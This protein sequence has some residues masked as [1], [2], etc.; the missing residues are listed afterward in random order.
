MKPPLNKNREFKYPLKRAQRRREPLRTTRELADEA[1]ISVDR[2]YV[3]LRL[4][5]APSPF[6][7]GTC[8]GSYFRP[9]EF[10]KWWNSLQIDR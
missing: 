4:P 9:S 7:R 10:Y 8:S 2:L 6:I 5:G 3:L 1:G